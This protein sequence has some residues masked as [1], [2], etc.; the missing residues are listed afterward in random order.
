MACG[1][2]QQKDKICV[3]SFTDLNCLLTP[4]HTAEWALKL[5]KEPLGPQRS[6]AQSEN[7]EGGNERR[8]RRRLHL[9]IFFF[10]KIL[11]AKNA[12]VF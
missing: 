6:P 2:Q 5:H 4:R 3:Y 9:I 1:A 12:L 11:P 7:E 8:R 10:F